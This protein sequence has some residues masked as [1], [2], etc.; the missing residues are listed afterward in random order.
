MTIVLADTSGL[1]SL[2][3]RKDSSH[4]AVKRFYDMLPH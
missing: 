2:L 3:N 1:Y 4:Q